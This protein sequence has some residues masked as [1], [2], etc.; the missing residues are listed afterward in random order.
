MMLELRIAAGICAQATVQDY[1][2]AWPKTRK[3][4]L[5]PGKPCVDGDGRRCH[6]RRGLVCHV[7]LQTGVLPRLQGKCAWTCCPHGMEIPTWLSS[8]FPFPRHLVGAEV[9]Q[10]YCTEKDDQQRDEPDEGLPTGA[11]DD[12]KALESACRIG[13]CQ[14]MGSGQGEECAAVAGRWGR[15]GTTCLTTSLDGRGVKTPFPS[16]PSSRLASQPASHA[17][18]HLWPLHS[19]RVRASISP[20]TPSNGLSVD[21]K[22]FVRLLIQRS[23]A[24]PLR[25]FQP[26]LSTH[27]ALTRARRLSEHAHAEASDGSHL[28]RSAHR[29]PE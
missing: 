6:W 26:P 27:S 12:A 10:Q 5:P 7:S 21:L 1:R 8:P 18:A 17:S 25:E 28:W 24:S 19:Q 13:D 11:G 29:V 16:N 20:A 4:R 22:V 14:W 15:T 3:R 23:S 9:G 2:G